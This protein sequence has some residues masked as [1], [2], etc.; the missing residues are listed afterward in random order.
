MPATYDIAVIGLGA[1][2]AATLHQLAQ[3]GVDA[4]GIDRHRPPHDIGSSHGESRV[5]RQAVGEGAAYVPLV[6]RSHEIWRELEAESGRRILV[7]DGML[8][9]RDEGHACVHGQ[10]DFI[11]ATM[12][13]ARDHGIAHE[14]LTGA[15]ISSRF[16]H[17]VTHESTVGYYEPGGGYVIP[18]AAIEVQLDLAARAGATI[19]PD[20]EV[21]GIE[22]GPAHVTIR[23]ATG[24]RIIAG[25]VVLAAGGW[26]GALLGR[27]FDRLLA[28]QRQVFHWF[29]VTPEYSGSAADEHH[30]TFIW[31]H[32]AED[33]GHFYG[34]A[35]RPGSCEVKLATELE[36]ASPTVGA[37]ERRVDPGE[38]LSFHTSHVAR[39][40][41]GVAPEPRRSQVCFYTTTPDH[42][43]IVDQHPESH[44]I[45]VISACS[46][47]GFKH[48][49]AIGEA[50][51]ER[52]VAGASRID[53][54]AF[55]LGRFRG[56]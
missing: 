48:S 24:D 41:R 2:G 19:A 31:L 1:M 29:P 50:V 32:G 3:R 42:G 15:E 51:A 47:H 5:T 16:P 4:I 46:G 43:F 27:P 11:D 39:R 36:A 25:H 52:L 55:A 18:E 54:A 44:R 7:A 34:F 35:P 40:M 14:R 26:T 30:P 28:L 10:A 17:L 53:L 6:M 22:P 49:S 33:T 38:G 8:I 45:T 21:V 37:I 9:L 13:L 56:K 20:T 12:R 23:T